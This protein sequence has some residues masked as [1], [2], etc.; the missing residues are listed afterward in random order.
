MSGFVFDVESRVVYPV[1][2]RMDRLAKRPLGE[3]HCHSRR[4]WV[5]DYSLADGAECRT[6]FT[7]WMARPT[8]IVHLY[9]PG[10]RYA[11]RYCNISSNYCCYIKFRGEN[12]SLRR[13]VE[14]SGGFA[15]IV[16]DGRLAELI[17]RTVRF[18]RQGN[19]GYYRCFAEFARIVELLEQLPPPAGADYQYRLSG[20]GI[21]PLGR[22]VRAC[23]ERDYRKTVTIAALAQELD[24]S[25]S[26][27]SH[28]YRAECGE[29]V[30]DTLLRI[31]A[32][33]SVPLLMKHLP[34]KLIAEETGFRSEFYY[35]KV[36]KKCFGTSPVNYR[37]SVEAGK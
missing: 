21:E 12:A 35:S 27:L 11:E 4:S 8:G 10:R 6:E 7:G 19:R 28:R 13:A 1:E 23:L 5:L 17:K 33:Q 20:T 31:R 18:A 25:V 29:S 34:L 16:D 15:R 22:R 9:P 3:L 37:K 32:E 30:F 24:C 14:N 36:F 26:T 2:A